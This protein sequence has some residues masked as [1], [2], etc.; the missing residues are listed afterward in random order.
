MKNVEI[1]FNLQ[2]EQ[3]SLKIVR[4]TLL[5]IVLLETLNSV[6]KV[7]II[8]TLRL[9]SLQIGRLMCVHCVLCTYLYFNLSLITTL[10][11]KQDL[12]LQLNL[13]IHLGGFFHVFFFQLPT[14]RS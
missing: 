12:K 2:L 5:F 11:L 14:R 7:C 6:I 9:L 4:T 3:T 8:C 1:F 10:R 13:K